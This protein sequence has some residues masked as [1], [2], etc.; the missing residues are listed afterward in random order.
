FLGKHV[1]GCCNKKTRDARENRS[2]DNTEFLHSV[3]LKIT[4]DHSAS[5][6]IADRTRAACVMTPCVV[7]DELAQFFPTLHIRP[8][9]FLVFNQVPKMFGHLASKLDAIDHR[10]E[11][12]MSRIG[13]FF[14]IMEIDLGNIA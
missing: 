3:N 7:S 9:K 8:W 4:V 10:L 5:I 12:L 2:V 6:G 14:E 11:V 13:P 1:N